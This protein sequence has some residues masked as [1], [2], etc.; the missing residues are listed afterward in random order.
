MS[1]FNQAQYLEQPVKPKLPSGLNV[2]TIL[3]FIGSAFD[4]LSTCWTFLFAK[5]GID[6]MEEMINS[7]KVDQLPVFL[8][9]MYTPEAMEMA[10]KAYENRFP[11]FLIGIV[12]VSLCVYGAIQMRKL[13]MQGYFLYVI[14]ELLPFVPVLLFIGAGSLSNLKGILTISFAALFILLYTLQ[15]KHLK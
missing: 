9:K 13:K 11:I 14:G 5:T 3:T 4:L 8:R 15:R 1:D 10:R 6:K 7:G 12:A 2:L